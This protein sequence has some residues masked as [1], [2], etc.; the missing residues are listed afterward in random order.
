MVVL[1][2]LKRARGVVK[3]NAGASLVDL[4][5]GVLCLEFH[6]KMNSLGEDAVQMVLR[7]DRGDGARTIR[8]WS[9]PTRARISASART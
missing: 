5:D 6:S 9:S 4:G 3:K 1:G 8:R 7:G 2:E